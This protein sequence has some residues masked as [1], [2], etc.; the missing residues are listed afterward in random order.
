MKFTIEI[1][2]QEKHRIDYYRNWFIGTER[3]SADGQLI[4]SRNVL[5]LSNYVSFPLCRRYEFTVGRSEPHT[6]VFEKQRPL[7]LLDFV[8]TFIEFSWMAS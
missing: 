7:L 1:G 2:Q 4:A 3:L 5:S 6:V 8:H